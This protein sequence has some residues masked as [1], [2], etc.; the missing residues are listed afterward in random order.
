MP[1]EN[2]GYYKYIVGQVYRD[3]ND[4]E[5]LPELDKGLNISLRWQCMPHVLRERPSHTYAEEKNIAQLLS[6]H[7]L[8]HSL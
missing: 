6:I 2:N 5:G 8:S 4:V 7:V 3:E 1:E